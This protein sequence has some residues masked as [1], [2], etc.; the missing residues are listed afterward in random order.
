MRSL[1]GLAMLYGN[2]IVSCIS[3]L[4]YISCDVDHAIFCAITFAFANA[5]PLKRYNKEIVAYEYSKGHS[6]V[7]LRAYWYLTSLCSWQ[8]ACLRWKV[9]STLYMLLTRRQTR[10]HVPGADWTYQKLIGPR[11]KRLSFTETEMSFW[12]TFRN[13]QRIFPV[14]NVLRYA[15]CHWW[16]GSVP[17]NGFIPIYA[18]AS[19]D[20]LN[21]GNIAKC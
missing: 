1:S 11:E 6:K 13:Q 16:Q 3:A 9:T 12:W 21:L 15:G 18:V 7:R 8:H 4:H 20:V 17:G 14:A 5:A 2:C 10:A 19:H